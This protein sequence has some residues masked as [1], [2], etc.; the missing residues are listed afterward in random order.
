MKDLNMNEI[1]KEWR[2]NSTKE[3]EN[4]LYHQA[5]RLG[6]SIYFKQ[7]LSKYNLDNDDIESSIGFAL[8]NSMRLYDPNIRGNALFTTYLSESIKNNIILVVRKK[9]KP[10]IYNIYEVS[11]DAPEFENDSQDDSISLSYYIGDEE[12]MTDKIREEELISEI[13]KKAINKFN[14]NNK[15]HIKRYNN[16]RTI[17]KL[18]LAGYRDI[19]IIKIL[20]LKNVSSISRV[21]IEL[22]K[23]AN[24]MEEYKEISG[25]HAYRRKRRENI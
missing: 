2:L 15:M 4:A 25:R 17:L 10:S 21:F 8:A 19:E 24:K 20:G 16:Y 23:G 9:I 6:F 14:P 12:D 18:V 5:I 22:R 13:C 7:G 1:F 11:L 3:L